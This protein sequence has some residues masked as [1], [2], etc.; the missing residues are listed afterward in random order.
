ML[1]IC[2]YYFN[3]I[4]FALYI[5]LMLQQQAL[6]FYFIHRSALSFEIIIPYLGCQ[7]QAL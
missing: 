5:I 2:G 3:E 4:Q 1:L 6:D 7:K